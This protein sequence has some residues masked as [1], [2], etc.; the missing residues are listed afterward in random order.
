VERL[1][2]PGA[3]GTVRPEDA[4][5]LHEIEEVAWGQRE[6]SRV[7]QALDCDQNPGKR[8]WFAAAPGHWDGTV[9][10]L[11][12]TVGATLAVPAVCPSCRTRSGW[13]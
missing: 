10:P 12:A 5:Y 7:L 2:E 8:P 4:A 3:G 1:S 13:I 9:E 6:Q 11:S